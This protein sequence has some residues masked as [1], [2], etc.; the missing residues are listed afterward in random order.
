MSYFI[1][2]PTE[3]LEILSL[4][5]LSVTNNKTSSNINHNTFIRRNTSRRGARPT[6][7]A[8]R[9]KYST[10]SHTSP[11]T[12]LARWHWCSALWDP[13]TSTVLQVSIT[14]QSWAGTTGARTSS[15]GLQPRDRALML[16]Y[17]DTRGR[18]DDVICWGEQR[19]SLS[20]FWLL[21]FSFL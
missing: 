2:T 14:A 17:R 11:G 6:T 15:A 16:P 12:I 21:M 19:L 5:L 20:L 7:K 4:L 1:L 3:R 13:L 10:R 18:W 9:D 8:A